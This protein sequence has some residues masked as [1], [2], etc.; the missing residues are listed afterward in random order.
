MKM[1]Q[2]KDIAQQLRDG[3]IEEKLDQQGIPVFIVNSQEDLESVA[4]K[5]QAHLE[6]AQL[7]AHDFSTKVWNRD[8]S[9]SV[10]LHYRSG[11]PLEGLASGEVE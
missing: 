1:E 11:W 6:E 9:K 7:V 5:L 10:P 8:Q 2:I 3:L 4:K